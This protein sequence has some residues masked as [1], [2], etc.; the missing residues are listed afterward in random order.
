MC[1]I[2]GMPYM[3]DDI[4]GRCFSCANGLTPGDGM[5]M[6]ARVRYDGPV[7]EMMQ[8]LKY[9]KNM[10]CPPGLGRE[11]L[12]LLDEVLLLK[13][14][15]LVVPVPLHEVRLR[16]RGFNLPDQLA[17]SLAS[18]LDARY[19]PRALKR[20]RN[21]QSQVGKNRQERLENVS[22]A[23]E[24]NKRD[25]TLQ[26]RSVILVDDVVTTGATLAAAAEPLLAE[27]AEVFA[28]ALARAF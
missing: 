14:R 12:P 13:P 10:D 7:A 1:P 15:L 23:F 8:S 16:Q 17:R 28:V 9:R 2:C 11:L 18:S 22:G 20:V 24:I 3:S 25:L 21:T 19:V 27:G 6:R 4:D 5:K 26:G